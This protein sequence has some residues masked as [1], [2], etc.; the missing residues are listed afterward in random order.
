MVLGFL[1]CSLNTAR[2]QHFIELRGVSVD[3]GQGGFFQ[4][5]KILE[6]IL[7]HFLKQTV[8]S[9]AHPPGAAHS[10]TSWNGSAFFTLFL[11]SGPFGVRWVHLYQLLSTNHT[12]QSV[13][14]TKQ[15]SVAHVYSTQHL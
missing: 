7:L 10:F 11:L 3:V 1:L 14:R 6:K 9:K 5:F 2:E 8:W 12:L 15:I 4:I 13:L